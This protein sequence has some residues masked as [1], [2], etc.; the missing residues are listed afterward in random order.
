MKMPLRVIV[1]A[2]AA[3][4][5]TAAVPA[6]GKTLTVHGPRAAGPGLAPGG[7]RVLTASPLPQRVLTAL[8]ARPIRMSV[9]LITAPG[10]IQAALPNAV[11]ARQS[12]ERTALATLVRP[13]SKIIGTS[14]AMVTRG[15]PGARKGTGTLV[16]LVAV[17]PYGG[18]PAA[19]LPACTSGPAYRHDIVDVIGATSGRWITAVSGGHL[20]PFRHLG[21]E[22]P[23]HPLVS[24]GARRA[25]HKRRS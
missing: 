10:A 16:W 11:A 25:C 18:V 12:A 24:P 20:P 14:L 13:H 22:P 23:R 4:L 1:I 2:V 15:L 8:R 7:I 17:N 3:A 9:T 6:C 19:S 21:P 5:V